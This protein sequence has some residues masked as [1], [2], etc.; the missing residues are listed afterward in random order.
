MSRP[1]HF[2]FDGGAGSYIGT[3]IL[4]ALIIQFT[5]M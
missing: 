5:K 1:E 3:G 4:A 2:K